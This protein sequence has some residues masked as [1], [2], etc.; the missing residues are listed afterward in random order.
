MEGCGSA[1]AFADVVKNR[2]R[3]SSRRGIL[4]AEAVQEA[5]AVLASHGVSTP[6]ELRGRGADAFAAIE[7]DWRAIQGHGSGLSWEY[8]L[9]LC[10][11]SGVKADR[12]IRRFVAEALDVSG[13]QVSAAHARGLVIA[14]SDELGIDWRVADFA[15]WNEMSNR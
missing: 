2:Q 1:D 7:A 5:A 14:A 11:I 6:G 4:K 3:T 10:G 15:V 9:M 13:A 12:H 8:F